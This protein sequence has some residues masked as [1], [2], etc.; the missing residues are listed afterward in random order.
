MSTPESEA[1][2]EEDAPGSELCLDFMILR[3][4]LGTNVPVLGLERASDRSAPL[5]SSRFFGLKT[6]T[7]IEITK[8][9]NISLASKLLL[10]AVWSQ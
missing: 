1:P 6:T 9:Q 5:L 3:T 10:L 8:Q 2:S 4:E 7:K